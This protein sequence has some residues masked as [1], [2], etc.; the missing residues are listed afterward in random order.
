MMTKKLHVINKMIIM[1]PPFGI[2][3][4]LP[5]RRNNRLVAILIELRKYT[6][7]TKK[8]NSQGGAQINVNK[9]R[10]LDVGFFY[11]LKNKF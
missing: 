6:Y 11:F 5:N 10:I 2:F 8:V 1:T 7:T 9:Y 3:T 4:P